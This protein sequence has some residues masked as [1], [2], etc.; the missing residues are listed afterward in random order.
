MRTHLAWLVLFVT[1]VAVVAV[2]QAGPEDADELPTGAVVDAAPDGLDDQL[3]EVKRRAVIKR[4]LVED[5][6]AGRRRL[7]AA[8]ARF[9]EMDADR[10][11]HILAVR[12]YAGAT[13]A[14][15]YSRVVIARVDG[16]LNGDP[17]RRLVLD[18]LAVELADVVAAGRQT[19]GTKCR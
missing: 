14:E 6:I 16:A 3:A 11:G 9:E 12:H 15:R 2:F 19:A 7:A 1:G 10:P 5:L 4:A 17:R 13:T 8:A 18:R